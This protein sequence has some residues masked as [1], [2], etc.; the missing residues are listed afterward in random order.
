[1]FVDKPEWV[2]HAGKAIHSVDIS[3]SGSRLATGGADNTVRIWNLAAILDV[4]VE[5]SAAPR[6]LATLREHLQAVTAARFSHDSRYLASASDDS[7][8][9]LYE[10]RPGQATAA[11]GSSD[12]PNLENWKHIRTFRG[13]SSN[14]AD[15]IWA[16]NSLT[17]VTCSV[18]N[19]IIVWDALTGRQA[20]TLSQH[21]SFVK[22]L[23]WD[24]TGYFLASHS[25]DKSIIV[26]R[27][28]DWAPVATLTEP[29][30]KAIDTTFCLR[31]GWS[32]DGQYLVA[33][34]S[35]SPIITAPMLKRGS[36][37]SANQL[38]GHEAP[39]VT[40]R[41]SGRLFKPPAV[42]AQPSPGQHAVIAVG[43]K[44]TRISI[45]STWRKGGA[46]SPVKPITVL[47]DLFKLPPVDMAWTPDGYSLLASSEDGTLAV[48]RFEESELGRVL[49]PPEME[50]HMAQLYGSERRQPG[51]LPP[52]NDECLEA[53]EP[54]ASEPHATAQGVNGT[55]PHEV[56]TA[57]EALAARLAPPNGTAA[58]LNNPSSEAAAA[59]RPSTQ[60]RAQ[61][62]ELVAAG[63]PD[64]GRAAAPVQAAARQRQITASAPDPASHSAIV[65]P[66]AVT[67]LLRQ[68]QSARTVEVKNQAG[69]A[70]L[71]V[72]SEGEKAWEFRL[73]GLALKVATSPDFVAVG[74]KSGFIQVLSPEGRCL[75]PPL[76]LGAAP[77]F[78]VAD[79]HRPSRLLAVSVTG[80]LRQW[81]VAT[82][83]CCKCDFNQAPV[84]DLLTEGQ[85][86]RSMLVSE[87]GDPLARLSDG[88]V[89][90]LH[91]TLRAWVLIAGRDS[92]AAAF[93]S[94]IDPSGTGGAGAG[95]MSRLQAEA[96]RGA[97]PRQ[98]PMQA[99]LA[100]LAMRQ[101]TIKDRE[102]TDAELKL[103]Q[104]QALA[105]PVEYRRWLAT[106][107]RM[108]ARDADE[109]RL[110]ELCDMLLSSESALPQ[111]IVGAAATRPADGDR[112]APGKPLLGWDWQRLLRDG[113]LKE[114][115]KCRATQALAMEMK[116][117]LSIPFASP[118]KP[119]APARE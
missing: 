4:K 81:D 38:R 17:L 109:A 12:S 44:D 28:E 35:N 23:A 115:V 110:R 112:A 31:F 93:A 40:A 5:T 67:A 63:R 2:T 45:W 14:I 25:D 87:A 106:Y 18:D 114:L 100:A 52:D 74:M 116:D 61:G 46:D 49:T 19:T 83:Q 77:A 118:I 111:P 94:L 7:L 22:G 53:D 30:T 10:V 54:A 24:P 11:F 32:P 33:V 99:A 117:R 1:M 91:P 27:T 107:A 13:H 41:C 65:E 82:W 56:A 42:A 103:A 9:C 47:R 72:K 86:V 6:L 89:W 26:W 37:Q 8:A 75:L 57:Q 66:D 84:S 21:R 43:S 113:V 97:V 34:N 48:V 73:Q 51:Y 20:H 95:E 16:P 88:T 64:G 102:R 105:S 3:S 79:E 50:A 76:Q 71:V 90:L 108:L 62:R 85:T 69:L 60:R 58:T 80:V 29:F 55:G 101:A 15:L 78:L 68:G 39:V 70:T 92:P 98:Q 96:V 119:A 104:A 59:A 36:W